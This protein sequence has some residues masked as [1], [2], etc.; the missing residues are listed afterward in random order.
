MFLNDYEIP[1]HLKPQ[2]TSYKVFY[3]YRINQL[4]EYMMQ[5]F[6]WHGLPDSIP[7]HEPDLMLFM[8]GKCAFNKDRKKNELIAVIPEQ[9]GCTNYF[10]MFTSYT[11]S[12]PIQ[13][14]RQYIDKNGII[15]SNTKLHNSSFPLIH[16]TAAKLAH[17][18]T[19]IICAAVN[20]RDNVAITAI[21]Q[22]F[23]ND[24]K[25]YQRQR[26]NGVPSF[27]VDKGF[28]TLEFRDLKSNSM[29]NIRE[30]SD[31]EQL[32]MSEFWE[33]IGVNK[34]VEKRERMITAEADSNSQLLKLNIRNMY[35][36]R[37]A[38]VQ[39]VN[40]MFGTDIKVECNV[41][42]VDKDITETAP[43]EQKEGEENETLDKEDR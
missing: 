5:L 25:Q 29:V 13:G 41:D 30:Y 19:T 15:I 16:C 24:A 35:E 17:L 36:S 12:T 42:I 7:E 37:V 40:E 34:T 26:Y 6:T 38:G 22:K 21:N 4:L 28:T 1:L 14:G 18:D 10:D 27:V 9:S 32:I 20:Q 2:S 3:D 11:W 23:A 8:W 33:A 31:T 39:K 43:D